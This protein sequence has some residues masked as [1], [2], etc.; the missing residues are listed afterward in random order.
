MSVVGAGGTARVRFFCLTAAFPFAASSAMS[1]D[2][3]RTQMRKTVRAPASSRTPIPAVASLRVDP[4]RLERMWRM[5]TA[6][7]IA[8]AQRGQLTL[9]EMLRWA[10]RFPTEPPR[11]NGDWF[12]ITALSADAEDAEAFWS[13]AYHP[14]PH[15]CDTSQQ[16]AAASD[17]ASTAERR[18]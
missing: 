10:C 9:G 15:P 3:R 18:C 1:N 13:G 4:E 7:R 14:V 5:S 2:R 16:A 6:E 12:F 17:T 8:A 11:V